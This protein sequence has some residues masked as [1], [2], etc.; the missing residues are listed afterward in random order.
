MSE[1]EEF[2]REPE[3]LIKDLLRQ[4]LVLFNPHRMA[5]MLEL[6]HAG[7]AEFPQ[8]KRDLNMTDGALATHLKALTGGKLLQSKREE[9][10]PRTRTAFIITQRGIESV[11]EILTT[12]CKIKEKLR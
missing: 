10:G 2:S 6:Y 1:V 8:L 3:M 12:M 7:G 11:E 4:P 9:V 5:I